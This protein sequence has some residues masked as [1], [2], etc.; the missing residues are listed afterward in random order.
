MCNIHATTEIPSDI[1]NCRTMRLRN[2]SP[3][4]SPLSYVSAT[5]IYMFSS[6][7]VCISVSSVSSKNYEDD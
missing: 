7:R 2:Q 5:S 1:Y 6:P 3:Y 4:S